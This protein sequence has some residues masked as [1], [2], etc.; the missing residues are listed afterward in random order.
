MRVLLMDTNLRRPG[1]GRMFGF[2]PDES[3]VSNLARFVDVRPPYPVVGICGT[4]VHVAALP[5]VADFSS[6]LERT[7]FSV[8][9]AELRTEYDYIVVD[10]GSVLESA[11]ADVLGECADG[12]VV[13]ARAGT[14]KKADLRRAI[15]QLR[16][17]AV[18]GTVL[19]DA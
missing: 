10:A 14:S 19:L 2:E 5:E 11:D 8:A 16:P 7:L 6:R 3:L 12:V 18:L 17:A 1:L 13:A 4:R 9:L 15:D